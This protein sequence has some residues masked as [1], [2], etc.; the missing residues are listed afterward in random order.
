MRTCLFGGTFNPIHNGHLILAEW[1]CTK[2]KLDKMIFV[3]AGWPPHK[4]S[5]EI[6]SG[7][8]RLK[9][10][11]LGIGNNDKFICSDMEI[12]K[13]SPSFT[14]EMI[15]WFQQEEPWKYDELFLLI[16]ADSLLDMHNWRTPENILGEI[17]ILVIPRPG[18]DLNSIKQRYQNKVQI[19]DSPCME[20]S[21]SMIRESIH[22]GESIRYFVP[23]KVAEYIKI[24]GLYC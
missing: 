5:T 1:V 8:H 6:S 11:Q 2:L 22:N 24:N 23:D 10:T 7:K 15:S 19:L 20:I 18:W 13:N 9:M 14:A 12:K 3:P 21:S 4:M 16:G 17:Q